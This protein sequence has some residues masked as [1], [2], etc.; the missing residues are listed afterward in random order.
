[1]FGGLRY[2][3]LQEAVVSNFY[4]FEPPPGTPFPDSVQRW[5][6]LNNTSWFWGVGPR[7]GIDTT[8]RVGGGWTVTGDFAGA[9]LVGRKQP[10]Q[11]V[12]R[13]QTP[14][15]AAIGIEENYEFISSD[16]FTD[17]VT[18]FDARLGIG[19]ERRLR[20]GGVASVELGF[21]AAVYNNAFMG[22]ETNNN[23]LALQIGSLSTA[24][25]RQTE[26]DFTLNGFYLNGGY[27]W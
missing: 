24:S 11:Y 1:L 15:L 18:A 17:V 9:L 10:S 21:M 20:R 8:C 19:Y 23:V 6:Q 2:S 16:D 12:F 26:S 22:Y 25:A 27:Q 5:I 4:D 14:D 7:F 3:R 13:A